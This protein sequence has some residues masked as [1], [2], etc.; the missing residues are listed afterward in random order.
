[1]FRLQN[2]T[3]DDLNTLKKHLFHPLFDLQKTVAHSFYIGFQLTLFR[4]EFTPLRIKKLE[5][6]VCHDAPATLCR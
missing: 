2:Q 1:M 4:I 5:G 6:F 3:E